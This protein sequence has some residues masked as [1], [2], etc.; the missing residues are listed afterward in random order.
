[1]FSTIGRIFTNQTPRQAENTDTRQ[2]IQ[3]HDPDYERRNKKRD[4]EKEELFSEDGATISVEA[5]RIFLENFLKSLSSQNT[6]NAGSKLVN[7][8]REEFLN[9]QDNAHIEQNTKS[10][11]GQTAHAIHA[12][13]HTSEAQQKKSLLED[14]SVE[15]AP[16]ISLDASEVRT[17]HKILEDLKT[18]EEKNIA[19]IHIERATT[20]L[21]SIS[22]AIEKILKH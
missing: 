5:L 10:I 19:Y 7:K 2:D 22:N 12:Y 11:S 21:Q 17:I 4:N 14:G 18:I 16:P 20:F 9:P 6:F 3:R 8:E 15:G 13:Q 1:M